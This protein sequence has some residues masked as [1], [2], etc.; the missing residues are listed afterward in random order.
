MDVEKADFLLFL[1]FDFLSPDLR[2]LQF[3][4]VKLNLKF[5]ILG[6][7]LAKIS[8]FLQL[9]KKKL[10]IVF[11]LFGRPISFRFRKLQFEVFEQSLTKIIIFDF[12]FQLFWGDPV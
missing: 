12:S 11:R 10:L 3:K 2:H 1:I 5:I 7:K 8:Y 9:L 4:N 6:L